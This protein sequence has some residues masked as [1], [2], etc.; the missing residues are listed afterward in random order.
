MAFWADHNPIFM[1]IADN[2]HK[3]ETIKW[4]CVEDWK[5]MLETVF[6]PAIIARI[7]VLQEDGHTEFLAPNKF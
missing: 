4:F 1:N 2:A 7:I 6:R 5:E 3:L